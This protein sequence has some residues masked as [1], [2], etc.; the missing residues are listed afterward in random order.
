MPVNKI[1]QPL[2][3]LIAKT[4][5]RQDKMAKRKQI[6]WEAIEKEFR[7]NQLSNVQIAKNHDISETAIRKKAKQ[8]GWKKDLSQR[9]RERVREKLVRD[10]VREPNA[11]D[12]KIVDAVAERG[13]KVITIH[14]QDIAKSQSLVQLFQGQLQEAATQRDEI[15]DS[16]IDETKNEEGKADQKRR[17]MMLK[18][19][20]LPAHS[21]VLRDL[22]IAQKNLIYLERQAFNID[23]G[24]DGE[25]L[26]IEVVKFKRKPKDED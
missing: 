4:A 22:T 6:D 17:N 20:S 8:Y 25:G 11:D 2:P 9:V 3:S 14:R 13:A 21:G 1:A 26:V 10:E 23:E 16:I 24:Q 5:R 18:A 15:K 12:E 7:V 19:V